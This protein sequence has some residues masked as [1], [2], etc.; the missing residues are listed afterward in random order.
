VK[1]HSISFFS[2]SA[3]P[4]DSH[5]EILHLDNMTHLMSHFM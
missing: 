3:M 4:S 1:E 2:Q 5:M